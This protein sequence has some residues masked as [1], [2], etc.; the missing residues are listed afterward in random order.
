MAGDF[1]A[2]SFRLAGLTCAGCAARSN[3]RCAPSPA[4]SSYSTQGASVL[5]DRARTR[6]S[7]LLAAVRG[8]FDG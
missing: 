2:R 3:E 8:H 6:A 5:W 7:E 1:P 4:W